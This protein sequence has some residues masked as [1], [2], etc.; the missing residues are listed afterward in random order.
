MNKLPSKH[1]LL[2]EMGHVPAHTPFF[3]FLCCIT[4]QRAHSY[5]EIE[6]QLCHL[7]QSLFRDATVGQRLK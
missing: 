4:R 5:L 7:I 3:F 1:G 6:K 2:L